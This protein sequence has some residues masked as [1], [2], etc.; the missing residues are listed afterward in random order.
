[1]FGLSL[2]R[3]IAWLSMCAYGYFY[4]VPKAA[5]DD[6]IT[7]M[8]IFL[9]GAVAMGLRGVYVL[10]GEWAYGICGKG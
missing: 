8:W 5:F 1:M 6:D 7:M 9:G 2:V 4:L 3:A 10:Y